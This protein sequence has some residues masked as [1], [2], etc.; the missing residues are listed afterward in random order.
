VRQIINGA[1]AHAAGTEDENIHKML[2]VSG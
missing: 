2:I 1:V